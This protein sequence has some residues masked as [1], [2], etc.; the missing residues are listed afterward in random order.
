MGE[1]NGVVDSWLAERLDRHHLSGICY[2]VSVLGRCY[3]LKLDGAL[4]VWLHRPT[5]Q[6]TAP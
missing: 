3:S 6:Q 1:M 5:S 2:I 4:G